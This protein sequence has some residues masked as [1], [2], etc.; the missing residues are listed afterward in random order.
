MDK[1]KNGSWKYSSCTLKLETVAWKNHLLGD[2][3]I[4]IILQNQS[5]CS[6]TNQDSP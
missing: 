2:D 3:G 1:I 4:D 6:S 5:S